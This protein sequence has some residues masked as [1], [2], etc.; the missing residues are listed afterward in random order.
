MHFKN[1]SFV[2]R[3]FYWTQWAPE[4][5][6]LMTFAFGRII[7]LGVRARFS[8]GLFLVEKEES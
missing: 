7:Y 8:I 4:Y 6:H 3:I 1:V 5:A 2:L